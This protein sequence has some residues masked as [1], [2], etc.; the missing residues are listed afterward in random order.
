MEPVF[1]QQFHV[2]FTSAPISWTLRIIEIEWAVKN[3]KPFNHSP[4][5]SRRSSSRHERTRRS[6]R[7]HKP[8]PDCEDVPEEEEDDVSGKEN[9]DT[10]PSPG[11][12]R[13]KI[14]DAE[15]GTPPKK[16]RILKLE[17]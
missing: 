15:L 10:N 11:K 7:K 1:S 14:E 3:N 13:I 8:D 4:K 9:M 6:K 5:K 12:R 2:S 16:R 17:D